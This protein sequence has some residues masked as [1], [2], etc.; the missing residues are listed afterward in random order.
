[1]EK[2][3]KYWGECKSL[4]YKHIYMKASHKMNENLD[5][6]IFMITIV[7]FMSWTIL[8]DLRQFEVMQKINYKIHNQSSETES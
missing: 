5:I 8:Y 4:K 6:I 3:K 7:Q 1:M 2:K